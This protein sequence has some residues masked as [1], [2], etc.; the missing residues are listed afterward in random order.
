MLLDRGRLTCPVMEEKAVAIGAERKRYIER[1]GII[2]RL[3]HAMADAVV[4]VFRLDNGNGLVGHVIKDVICA[5]GLAARMELAAD[6]DS[7]GRE[8]DFFANLEMKIPSS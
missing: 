3:L 6:D 8:A 1:F 7:A 5:L 4:I 2:K